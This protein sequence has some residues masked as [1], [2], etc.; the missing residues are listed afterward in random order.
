LISAPEAVEA[1]RIGWDATKGQLFGVVLKL[2]F[3]AAMF[4]LILI[5]EFP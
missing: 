1:L 5:A 4:L 3:G 2:A